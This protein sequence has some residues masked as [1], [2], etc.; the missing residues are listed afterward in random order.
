MQ[1]FKSLSAREVRALLSDKERTAL[2]TGGGFSLWQP[3]FDDL[4]VTSQRQFK[5]K[6]DYIHTN[7]VRAGLAAEPSDWTHSSAG[8]WLGIGES[9]IPIDKDFSWTK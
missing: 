5:I 4:I 3:R 9:P 1:T 6:L 2:S 7:P 8:A